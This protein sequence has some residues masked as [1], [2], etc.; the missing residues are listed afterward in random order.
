MLTK[1]EMKLLSLIRRN[2]DSYG[3]R[4]DPVVSNEE[5]S[6][7]HSTYSQDDDS[8]VVWDDSKSCEGRVL[9]LL[10]SSVERDE[11]ASLTFVPMRIQLLDAREEIELPKKEVW[12]F[13]REYANCLPPSMSVVK[14]K[15]RVIREPRLVTTVHVQPKGLCPI[16]ATSQE[17]LRFT[18]SGFMGRGECSD[19]LGTPFINWQDVVINPVGA[20]WNYRDQMFMWFGRKLFAPVDKPRPLAMPYRASTTVLDVC[21]DL[22]TILLSHGLQDATPLQSGGFPEGLALLPI[23]DRGQ[24]L[25]AAVYRVHDLVAV[26]VVVPTRRSRNQIHVRSIYN[27]RKD[28]VGI[29]KK[30]VLVE[31]TVEAFCPCP[32]HL[33]G[34]LEQPAGG[35][36]GLVLRTGVPVPRVDLNPKH[37]TRLW[38]CVS[39]RVEAEKPTLVMLEGALPV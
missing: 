5:D 16:C 15:A 7:F 29:G 17:R 26:C 9:P 8:F 10:T 14:R 28:K 20:G 19:L 36:V 30:H 31:R 37:Y 23:G 34:W 22:Q 6:A 39:R 33:S 1:E 38:N 13:W 25:R 32:T 11:D 18:P 4:A 27:P 2:E 21:S 3:F 12:K 35:L 24:S